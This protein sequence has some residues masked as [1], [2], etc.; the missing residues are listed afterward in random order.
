MELTE[1]EMKWIWD[2]AGKL[3]KIFKLMKWTWKPKSKRFIPDQQK[4][5]ENIKNHFLSLKKIKELGGLG[6]GRIMCSPTTDEFGKLT[7]V[8]VYLV[9][10]EIPIEYQ[11]YIWPDYG[12]RWNR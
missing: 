8:E 7:G 6:S 4:I 3:A 5:Y 11:E 9:I 10:G 12:L 2:L 1:P